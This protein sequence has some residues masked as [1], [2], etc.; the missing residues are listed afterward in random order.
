MGFLSDVMGAFTGGAE[1]DAGRQAALGQREA[2]EL[3]GQLLPNAQARFQPYQQ[4]GQNALAQYLQGIGQNA[5]GSDLPQF[6]Y[7][8]EI[9]GYQSTGQFQFNQ[10]A[11]LDNPAYQ[12]R[13]NQGIEALNRGA[14]ASGNLGSGNRLNALMDLGQN[15]ASQEY[16][17]EFQRQ[18]AGS[19]TNYQRGVTDYGLN[20]AREADQYGRATQ[21]YLFGTDRANNLYGRQQNY[22]G[23]LA[24]LSDMGLN[25]NNLL[26]NVD[27]NATGGQ[28][29]ARIGAANNLAAG[30]LGSA[31]AI[32]GTVN[33]L[34][35]AAGQAGGFGNLFGSGGYSSS[36]TNLPGLEGLF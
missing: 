29:N 27:L 34:L 35:G 11:L 6:Q 33:N 5:P 26:T 16:E 22:L 9:P 13:L 14:G 17:N 25:V 23:Q 4:A 1:R 2:A 24:G 30:T 10:N 12:F 28:A 3:Y 20:A 31:G 8:G 36:F 21:N 7:G 18:L 15:M 32:R 19:N